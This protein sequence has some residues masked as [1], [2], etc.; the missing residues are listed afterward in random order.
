[1][2]YKPYFDL[3]GEQKFWDNRAKSIGDRTPVALGTLG[4][5]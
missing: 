2:P 5:R 1:M 4:F 3:H